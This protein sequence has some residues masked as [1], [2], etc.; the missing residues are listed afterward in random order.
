M[1]AAIVSAAGEKPVWG[2]FP[3]PQADEQH[4]VVTVK[5]AAISQLAKARAAGSHYSAGSH[6]PFIAGIDGTAR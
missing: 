6:Y 1:K 4:V 2:D 3:P 5:A